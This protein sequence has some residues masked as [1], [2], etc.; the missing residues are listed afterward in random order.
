MRRFCASKSSRR[1]RF[2]ARRLGFETMESRRLLAGMTS[3]TAPAPLPVETAEGEAT[4]MPDF[5]LVDLNPASSRYNQSISPRDYLEQV[6]AWY[7]SH[8]T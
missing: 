5:H 8:S 4:A 6:S 7:F 2:S 1:S 3:V